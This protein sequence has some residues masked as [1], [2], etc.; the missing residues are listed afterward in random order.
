M[1][2]TI[3]IDVKEKELYTYIF[4]GRHGKYEIKDSKKYPLTDRYDFFVDSSAG[5]L[6]NAYLS[7]PL[8]SLNFRV[9]D[10][11]F[12]DKNK[13]REILPFELDGMILGGSD[14]VVFDSVIVGTSGNKY[15]VL[16]VYIEKAVIKQILE[17]L[18]SFNIDPEV[19]TSIEL[20]DVLRDFS[21][22]K[23][24]AP[25]VVD[26]QNR[27]S[28]SV[29]ELKTPT[30]N[31]RRDEVSFTRDIERT[32][33]SLRVT[34]ILLTLLALVL[35]AD[36]L[37][38]IV[39][40]RHEIDSLKKDIRKVY[41]EVFPGEKNI[42]NELYQLKA[43][44]KE[45][46]DREEFIIGVDPLNLLLDL[47]VID[48]QGVVFDEITADRGRISLKGEAKSLSYIQEVKTGLERLFSDVDISDTKSSAQG[49]MLFTIT[50]K[51]KT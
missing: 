16:A 38:K 29:E 33:K 43:H 18:K 34:A 45:L 51:E 4:E 3:F 22:E 12:S 31:L 37:L 35:S 30:I 36:L 39:Y 21:L 20:R 26:D 6:E 2:K 7:L 10:L 5:D 27:I 48:K 46:K 41:Q 1:N 13:I 15:Q 50:A 44:M 28:L 17:K 8:S 40:T 47:S 32:K 14:R 11:P 19:I 25:A 23:V 9:I 42:V 24:L 49:K